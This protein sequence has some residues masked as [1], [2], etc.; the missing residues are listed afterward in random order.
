MSGYQDNSWLHGRFITFSELNYG[1]PSGYNPVLTQTITVIQQFDSSVG[2]FRSIAIPVTQILDPLGEVSFHSKKLTESFQPY[3]LH[4]HNSP[5]SKRT[6]QAIPLHN[7]RSFLKNIIL[8]N[9]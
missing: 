8:P 4:S 9:F 7:L 5:K 1:R 2:D 3:H 6:L